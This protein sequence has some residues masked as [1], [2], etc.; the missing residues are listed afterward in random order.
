MKKCFQ[1][2]GNQLRFTWT[3]NGKEKSFEFYWEPFEG[4]L[5][6][7]IETFSKWFSEGDTRKKFYAVN[8]L[9]QAK[10]ESAI[11]TLIAA[12]KEPGFPGRATAAAGLAHFKG[13]RKVLKALLDA[14]SSADYS[15]TTT[16]ISSLGVQGGKKA[17]KPL[18]K[19]LNHCL[20]MK[21]L[22]TTEPSAAPAAVLAVCT[23]DS[24]LSLGIADVAQEL[25]PFFEHPHW[26]VRYRAAQAASKNPSPLYIQALKKL[27]SACEIPVRVQ[28]AEALIR[29]GEKEGRAALARSALS[30]DYVERSTAV[31]VLGSLREESAKEILAEALQKEEDT[32]LR[33]EIAAHLINFT[34]EMPLTDFETGLSGENPFIRL[35]AITLL[36]RL[37]ALGSHLSASVREILRKAELAE[38]DEFLRSQIRRA[39]QGNLTDSLDSK[40]QPH[41]EG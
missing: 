11:P 36:S 19:I 4:S 10:D 30:D 15:L 8:L 38:P 29:N 31:S 18:R 28:S 33:M 25:L 27:S 14:L 12:A 32:S 41:L 5:K 6:S 16:A 21:E 23:I 26:A 7:N 17:I 24:L 3:V 1:K 13:K 9:A 20:E 22:F 40:F 2:N 37:S 39:L 34:E 35:Q